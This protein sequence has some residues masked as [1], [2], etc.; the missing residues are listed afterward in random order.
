M[1]QTNEAIA[2]EA[3]AA[4]EVPPPPSEAA[5][6]E[7]QVM[8]DDLVAR[9][10]LTREQADEQL[11]ADGVVPKPVDDR[12]EA[13]KAFD[14][15]HPPAAAKDYQMPPLVHPGTEYGA[16][17]KAAD[18]AG[19]E[20]LAAGRWTR[21]AGSSLAN[22]VAKVATHLD[23]KTPAERQL[24]AQSER[25]KLEKIWGNHYP[26]KTAMARQLIQELDTKHPGLARL[27]DESGAGASAMI[28]AQ[29]VAQAERLQMRRG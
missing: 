20:W 8:A 14:L 11:R 7:M 23:N 6:A 17:E 25:L 3:T 1:E 21:E 29:L 27:L 18:A 12:T 9:G 26:A 2:A 16:A 15:E 22:E 19:R 13:Q 5:A 28:Q 24:Y 4:P 10:L